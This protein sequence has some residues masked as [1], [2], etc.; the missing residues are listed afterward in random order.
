MAYF[1]KAN[2]LGTSIIGI[3][4]CMCICACN[5]TTVDHS[6]DTLPPNTFLFLLEKNHERLEDSVLSGLRLYYYHGA[7]KVYNPGPNMDDTSYIS[8]GYRYKSSLSNTGIMA[9]GYV[10]MISGLSGVHDFYLEFPDGDVD[11]LYIETGNL[12]N[13]EGANDPCYCRFPF[14]VVRYNGLDATIDTQ[15]STA[16]EPVFLFDKM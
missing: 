7:V 2:P 10:S 4:L 12:T 6:H 11:T 15:Y 13:E 3:L 8:P 16:G 1:L 5:R 9:S 14:R